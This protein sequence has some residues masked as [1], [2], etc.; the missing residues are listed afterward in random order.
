MKYTELAALFGEEY[1][2]IIFKLLNKRIYQYYQMY[3]LHVPLDGRSFGEYMDE[4]S[5]LIQSN[6]IFLNKTIRIR[7]WG[8]EEPLI[9]ITTEARE[10]NDAKWTDSECKHSKLCKSIDVSVFIENPPIQWDFED[11]IKHNPNFNM[12][13]MRNVIDNNYKLFKKTVNNE[14]CQHYHPLYSFIK[15]TFIP[16][17][18]WNKNINAT[19]IQHYCDIYD[20]QFTID[21]LKCMI[22]M[23]RQSHGVL[24]LDWY[25]ISKH[26]NIT[27]T[28]IINNKSVRFRWSMQGISENSNLT[29]EMLEKLAVPAKFISINPNLTIEYIL[30]KSKKCNSSSLEGNLHSDSSSDSSSDSNSDSELSFNW[31]L[32]SSHPNIDV[33]SIFKHT[34]L[35]WLYGSVSANPN[36]KMHHVMHNLDKEWDWYKV[37]KNITIDY[38][39]IYFNEPTSIKWNYKQLSSNTSIRLYMVKNHIDKNW[40]WGE[41][42][43]NPGI[44]LDMI[45]DNLKLPWKWWHISSNP[46]VTWEFVKKYIHKTW[47]SS[48]LTKHKNFTLDIIYNNIVHSYASQKKL[49]VASVWSDGLSETYRYDSSLISVITKYRSDLNTIVNFERHMMWNIR[50]F[51]ENPTF[52]ISIHGELL[53]KYIPATS[54]DWKNL[55]YDLP[56]EFIIRNI[57]CNWDWDIISARKDLTFN[58]VLQTLTFS[59]KLKTNDSLYILPNTDEYKELIAKHKAPPGFSKRKDNN[60]DTVKPTITNYSNEKIMEKYTAWNWKYISEIKSLTWND[61]LGYSKYIPWD[62]S[63]LMKGNL[64]TED[65]VNNYQIRWQLDKG[66]PIHQWDIYA[67]CHNANISHKFIVDYMLSIASNRNITMTTDQSGGYCPEYIHEKLTNYILEYHSNFDT[68]MLSTNTYSDVQ[69]TLLSQNNS[70]DI[71]YIANNTN[72]KWDILEL[73]SNNMQFSKDKWIHQRRVRYIKALQIQRHWRNCSCNP[74]FKLAQRMLSKLYES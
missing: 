67:L 38:S 22:Y 34:Q 20:D 74:E 30:N 11:A 37:S 72:V 51:V 19:H 48:E 53:I 26:K 73:C 9:E 42:S 25:I 60:S 23:Y 15:N 16:K 50:D 66:S 14:D 32:L 31:A 63:I 59:P 61:V 12:N 3:S 35:P 41:L 62:W 56:I 17:F 5:M 69:I 33:E 8:D 47:N 71:N 6:D 65:I 13:F 10:K 18:N 49:Y 4:C 58:I 44:T 29:P 70:L 24:N 46:N 40:N 27:Y 28:D 64:I 2:N 1:I 45:E 52:D 68:C 54:P 43:K 21:T 7:N 36:L 57:E 55:S 39:P